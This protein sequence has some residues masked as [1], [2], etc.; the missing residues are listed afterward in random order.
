LRAVENAL[1]L[2]IPLNAQLI[3]NLIIAAHGIHDHIVHFYHLSALDW[4]DIVSALKADPKAA[5][6]LAQSL[7]T[8][9]TTTPSTSPNVQ[10]RLKTFVASGQL[11]I[12]S[13]GYWGHPA[14]KL[15]PEANLMA[16]RI[17]WRPWTY[18][19]RSNQITAILGAKTPHVQNLAVGGVANAINP[20]DQSALN[21]ERLAYVKT[22]MDELGG[23]VR[24][25]YLPDVTAI[26]AL[27]A[28]WLPYG[29]GVTNYLSAPDFPRDT[30][31]T[32]FGMPG[33]YIPAGDLSQFH[34][35]SH[36]GDPFFEGN[37]KESIKHSWYAGR[38]DTH[39]L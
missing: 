31:G 8:G 6:Q 9:P 35:I 11:G 3:R 29:E 38:L 26:A 16:A 20:D 12:F 19:R 21:M 23:F 25:V 34:Q 18:Q 13:H 32:D 33:G 24:E 36:F 39:A 1:G 37:V 5:A 7:S 15:P 17:T 22:L 2:E 14:M 30:K 10:Q 4:V 27:Y 28:D